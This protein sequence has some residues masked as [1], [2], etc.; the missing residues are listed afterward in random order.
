MK[1]ATAEK[2]DFIIPA[3]S[4]S[5]THH[6]TRSRQSEPENGD[7]AQS[8]TGQE[9]CRWAISIPQHACEDI[10]DENDSAGDEVE[11]AEGGAT[12]TGGRGIGDERGKDALREAHV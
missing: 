8:R 2:K 11:D 6:G 9:R 3:S 4:A 12:Q 10:A 1:P 5:L 7:D